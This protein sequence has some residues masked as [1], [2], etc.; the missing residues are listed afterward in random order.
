[1]LDTPTHISDE[2]IVTI[3]TNGINEGKAQS[4]CIWDIIHIEK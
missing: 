1:M 3:I 4:A 2:E